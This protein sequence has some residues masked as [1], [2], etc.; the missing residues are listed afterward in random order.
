MGSK[1]CN[2]TIAEKAVILLINFNII[3]KRAWVFNINEY[4]KVT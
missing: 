1:K 4:D 2:E 3:L